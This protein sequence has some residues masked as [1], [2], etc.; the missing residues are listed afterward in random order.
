MDA[1]KHILHQAV[2]FCNSVAEEVIR[3]QRKSERVHKVIVF[4]LLK[5]NIIKEGLFV[6][7]C[8]W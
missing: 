7:Y 5:D 4:Q 8:F 2:N 1:R 3:G 6:K